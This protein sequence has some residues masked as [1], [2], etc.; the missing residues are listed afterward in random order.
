[1]DMSATYAL[2][3]NNLI[4]RAVQVI[5]KYHSIK[6][7]Y[8]ALGDVR[9]QAV[10]DLQKQLTKGTKRNGNDKLILQKIELLRR[11]SHAIM[12]SPD[13]WSE[14][15]KEI[16][17]QAFEENENLKQAYEISQRF[18]QWYGIENHRK[19]IKTITAEL[20][21]WYREAIQIKEF[22]SVIKMLHKHEMG[23]INFFRHGLTNAKAE[24][25]N[26][27]MQRFYSANYGTHNK[28]FF[29]YRT[30]GYFS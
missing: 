2:V 29:L 27:K 13:K 19:S 30:A 1:M 16:V 10:K 18:K 28:D 8:D 9:R 7:V 15:T 25:L 3:F 22:D 17:N 5:D 21:N 4:P 6:Y 14:G 12:Q 23:I 11:I 26:G 20:H 24:R